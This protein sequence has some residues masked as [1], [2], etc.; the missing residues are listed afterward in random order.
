MKFLGPK[1]AYLFPKI[2]HK[3]R[4][5]QKI[6]K[7]SNPPGDLATILAQDRKS[8]WDRNLRKKWKFGPFRHDT[9]KRLFFL[10]QGFTALIGRVSSLKVVYKVPFFGGVIFGLFWTV[11]CPFL[12]GSQKVRKVRF[13]RNFAFLT[14]N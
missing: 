3:T 9:G 10:L 13:L 1:N 14:K 7:N 5:F 8:F 2:V 6:S 11:F 4:F 12:G